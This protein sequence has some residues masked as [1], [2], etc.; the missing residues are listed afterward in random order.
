LVGA[1][2][3]AVVGGR[4]G[5]LVGALVGGEMGAG[6][7]GRPGAGAG[8]GA[9]MPNKKRI[10]DM[11]KLKKLEKGPGAGSRLVPPAKAI[12]NVLVM[13]DPLVPLAPLAENGVAVTVWLPAVSSVHAKY[14]EAESPQKA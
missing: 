10:M 14:K 11:M 5:A 9:G 13:V 6:S 3:G 7:T 1:F 2:V 8:A 4:I 12:V